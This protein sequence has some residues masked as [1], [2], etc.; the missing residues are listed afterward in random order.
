MEN[1]VK[2]IAAEGKKIGLEIS[3]EKKR[4]NDH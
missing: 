2:K 3:I 4:K 1:I